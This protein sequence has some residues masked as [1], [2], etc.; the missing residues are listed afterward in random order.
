MLRGQLR[1][2]EAESAVKAAALQEA[3]RTLS[4]KESELAKLTGALD[5]RSVLTD[6]QK[7]EIVALRGQLGTIEAEL[8]VKAAALQ[9]AERT[10][11]DKESELAKLTVVLDEH[12]GAK[13]LTDN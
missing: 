8:A 3:E 6:S 5:E 13:G 11:S 4:D 1:A 12:V 9:D 2:I 7:T 10:L